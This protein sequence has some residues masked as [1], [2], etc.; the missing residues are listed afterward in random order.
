M[1]MYSVVSDGLIIFYPP[2][3]LGTGEDSVYRFTQV[4]R[5]SDKIINSQQSMIKQFYK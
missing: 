2:V 1:H 4:P 5:V 3:D